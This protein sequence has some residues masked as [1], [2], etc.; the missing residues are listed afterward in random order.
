MGLTLQGGGS[1]VFNSH[2]IQVY[3]GPQ[4]GRLLYLG[5]Q[6]DVK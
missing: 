2:N 1:N 5:L 6:L 4:I 3:G